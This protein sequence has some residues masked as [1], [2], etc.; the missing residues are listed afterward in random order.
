MGAYQRQCLGFGSFG[1]VLQTARFRHVSIRYSLLGLE[2]EKAAVLPETNA[3]VLNVPP[4]TKGRACIMQL[5]KGL[6]KLD[7][8]EFSSLHGHDPL[9][10]QDLGI[11]RLCLVSED[12]HADYRQ[13]VAQG[14]EFLGP[15]SGVPSGWPMWRSAKTLMGTLIELIQVHLDPGPARRIPSPRS[16]RPNP[17][18]SP[19]LQRQT[20]FVNP[21]RAICIELYLPRQVCGDSA[22]CC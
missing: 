8:T 10:N 18:D 5:D 20:V 7:L 15:P 16:I 21:R 12:V 2:A 4:G 6:P 1:G 9:R 22:P 19:V 13:L 14:V 11:V 3:Q 17:R